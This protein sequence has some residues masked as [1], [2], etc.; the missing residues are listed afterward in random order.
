MSGATALTIAVI[1]ILAVLWVAVLAPPI[2]RARDRQERADSVGSFTHQLG[3]LGRANG[4]H[5]G[6]TARRR[7]AEPLMGPV[8]GTAR[9]MSDCQRRRRDLLL[10]LLTVA[11]LSLL[12]A[13]VTRSVPM[14]A[15]HLVAD[16]A[17]AGYVYLLVQHKQRTQPR[18]APL[19]TMADEYRNAAPVYFLGDRHFGDEP[20]MPR[21]VPLHQSASR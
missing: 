19:R 7:R 3:L 5:H 18:R 17:L 21:L 12:A 15:V 10:A 4:T 8:A 9:A 11:G 6:P 16:A 13:F 14:F 20:D 1:L 2:L